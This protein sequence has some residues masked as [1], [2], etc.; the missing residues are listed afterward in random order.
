MGNVKKNK[1]VSLKE[2]ALVE[3]VSIASV[4]IALSGKTGVS[5]EV[6]E[7]I[8]KTA[9]KMGYKAPP[10][11]K[12][13]LG[14]VAVL[15]PMDDLNLHSWNIFTR[16]IRGIEEYLIGRHFF[17]LIV[18]VGNRISSERIFEKLLELGAQSVI[19]LHYLDLPLFQKLSDKG[20]AV[21][22]VN[23]DG[24][25]ATYTSVLVDNFQGAYNAA[26]ELTQRGHKDILY[27][28][29][30]RK[31]LPGVLLDRRL[32]V[33]KAKL[34]FTDSNFRL[35]EIPLHCDESSIEEVLRVIKEK[36]I[37]ALLLHDDYL[38]ASVYM[39]L[40]KRGYSIPE[41]LS[42]IS[43]G[44]GVLDHSIASTPQISAY[45]LNANLIGQIAGEEALRLVLDNFP[46][47]RV[48]KIKQDFE[49]RHSIK[50]LRTDPVGDPL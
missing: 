30:P 37:T 12:K 10:E 39:A 1:R 48:L 23:N 33:Q 40:R 34:E 11:K 20:I 38:T 13:N 19:S 44:G 18:P 45:E 9:H 35:L 14:V 47:A 50:N 42:M 6:A 25:E 41:D 29:Y 28:D 32:G 43:T 8:R 21:V 49:D 15:Q 4:S 46:L 27:I 26:N 7:R 36:G 31:D 22:I 24:L 2:I 3:N 5:K 16:I 17:P